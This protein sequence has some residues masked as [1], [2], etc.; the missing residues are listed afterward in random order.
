MTILSNSFE[1]NRK[2]VRMFNFQF[3]IKFNVRSAKFH[4]CINPKLMGQKLKKL[5]LRKFEDD[6]NYFIVKIVSIQNL[7]FM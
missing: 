1:L 3:L 6:N 7:K 5:C 4:L 2:I